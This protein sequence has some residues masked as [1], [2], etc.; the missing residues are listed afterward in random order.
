MTQKYVSRE[1]DTVFIQKDG[2][3]ITMDIRD[4]IYVEHRCRTI[5]LH[6]IRGIFPMPYMTLYAVHDNLGSDYLYQCHK[7]FLVN[8]LYVDQINPTENVIILKNYFGSVSVGRHY[9]K[10]FLENMHYN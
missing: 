10:M 5:F 3:I 7:S 8:W 6:T 2:R 9:R 4:I 1:K